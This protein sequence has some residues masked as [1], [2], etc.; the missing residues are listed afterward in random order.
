MCQVCGSEYLLD[1]SVV[2]VCMACGSVV[3]AG[4]LLNPEPEEALD[5]PV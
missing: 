2:E 3:G 4:E 5:E 1:Y